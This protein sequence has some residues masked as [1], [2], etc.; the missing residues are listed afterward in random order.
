[1]TER[2]SQKDALKHYEYW[3][4]LNKHCMNIGERIMDYM[5]ENE[6]GIEEREEILLFLANRIFD[7][8]HSEPLES[9]LDPYEETHYLP[10]NE[11][12]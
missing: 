8:Y 5:R 2:I 7:Q 10:G 6:I 9:S 12:K 4:K 11:K 1:M 3:L